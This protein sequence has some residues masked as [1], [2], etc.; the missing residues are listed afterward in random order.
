MAYYDGAQSRRRGPLRA[1]WRTLALPTCFLSQSIA[2][3]SAGEGMQ[4][5]QTLCAPSSL[6]SQ[7]AINVQCAEPF[8]SGEGLQSDFKHFL[9]CNVACPVRK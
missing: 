7:I 4:R 9:C 6:T 2:L 1:R 3:M 5:P 8:D